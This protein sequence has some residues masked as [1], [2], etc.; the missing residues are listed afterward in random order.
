MI[1]G[2]V[3]LAILRLETCPSIVSHGNVDT[4]GT[5]AHRYGRNHRSSSDVDDR[6]RISKR[7]GDVREPTSTVDGDAVRPVPTEKSVPVVAVD[8]AA[9]HRYAARR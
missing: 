2:I 7:I 6:D 1:R 3:P 5:V 9:D 4:V 8:V